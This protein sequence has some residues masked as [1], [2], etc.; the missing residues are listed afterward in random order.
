MANHINLKMTNNMKVKV[1]REK[2]LVFLAH[3]VGLPY[4]KLF[5]KKP[6]FPYSAHELSQ[7]P[8][9]TV[10]YQMHLFFEQNNIGLLPYYEKHDIKHIILN[11]PPTE[12]GE[13]CLQTFML[14]NG[15]ITIPVFIAVAYGWL[16]MPEY[17]NSFKKAWVR[18]R[19]NIS[20][21]DLNWFALVPQNKEEAINAYIQ[22]K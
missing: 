5:R 6:S 7:M 16:T 9:T 18:G 4:F 2:L 20:L 14:A 10:G 11:Y 13:V 8:E 3:K 12:E 21:N 22:P 1:L 15:R 19:K 17:W